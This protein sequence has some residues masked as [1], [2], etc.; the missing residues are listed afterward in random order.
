M[1][2][3]IKHYKTIRHHKMLVMKNCFRCGL[4]WQ[5]LTH[6]LSKLAPVEFWAGAKYW[7]GT[8]SPN[9]AQRQAEGYSA[10]WLHHKGRNKHHLEY[11]IDYAPDGDH[12]MAGM[13]MPA[14]YV[15]EMVCDRIAASKNYKGDKYTDAA[16]WEYYDRSRDHYILHPETR[17]ELETCL[18]ELTVIGSRADWELSAA[19]VPALQ[20]GYET[21]LLAEGKPVYDLLESISVNAGIRPDGTV[22]QTE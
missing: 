8:C 18:L 15:A 7:Q 16:A 10:A 5:G 21:R 9:N 4:Y 17:K 11:W 3:P 14:R 20:S 19:V 1:W 22:Y 6:D 2:H 13:R 12:A